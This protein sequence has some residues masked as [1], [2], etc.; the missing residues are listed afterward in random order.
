MSAVQG[1][2]NHESLDT[3]ERLFNQYETDLSCRYSSHFFPS[4]EKQTGN[5][6]V[7]NF[8]MCWASETGNL[9]VVKKLLNNARIDPSCNGNLSIRVASENGHWKIVKLL[10]QDGRVDPGS[11]NNYAIKFASENGHTEVVRLL[12]KNQR[13]DPSAGC[14]LD[15]GDYPIGFASANG[16]TEIVRILLEDS[17]VNPSICNNFALRHACKNGHI[18]VVKLL[19]EKIDNFGIK[20]GFRLGLRNAIDYRQKEVIN[21]LVWK[22]VGESLLWCKIIME[23]MKVPTDMMKMVERYIIMSEI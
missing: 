22:L 4:L 23:T 9:E 16:H 21:F 13:V 7:G 15:G 20:V 8:L 3:T 1:S 11:K 2:D 6:S 18:E 12:L 19:C 10:L 5:L 14:F 17:T